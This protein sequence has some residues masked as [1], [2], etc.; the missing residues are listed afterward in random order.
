ERIRDLAGV[1][2]VAIGYPLPLST[3]SEAVN[4]TIDGYA[5]PRDQSSLEIGS[6]IVDHN[7]FDT[8][9]IP[10]VRGREFDTRDTREAARVAI[11]NQA[12]ADKYWLGQDPLGSRMKLV[13]PFGFATGGDVQI[14]GIARTTKYRSIN[15]RSEPFLYLP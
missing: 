15:E 2:S 12:M 7:Y 4:V 11:I 6:A 3:F 13:E 5:M 10:I 9:G 1:K 14:V 8:L